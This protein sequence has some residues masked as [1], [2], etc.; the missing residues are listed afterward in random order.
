MILDGD[1]RM[2]NFQLNGSVR[3][4]KDLINVSIDNK[5]ELQLVEVNVEDPKVAE[6]LKI[7]GYDLLG[8]ENIVT[9]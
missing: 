8:T 3:A 4:T 1:I 6:Y 2:E 9:V 5:I 7:R